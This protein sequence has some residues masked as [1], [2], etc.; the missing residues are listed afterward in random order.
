[1][2][3]T[4]DSISRYDVHYKVDDALQG[5][6]RED[7][8]RATKKTKKKA[9]P[10]KPR[11]KKQA[12]AR[13]KEEGPTDSPPAKKKRGRPPGKK[14]KAPKKE[15]AAAAPPAADPPRDDVPLDDG[16][17]PWRT[18]GHAYLGR[19]VRWTPPP[20]DAGAAA[21]PPRPCL[22]TV[23][24]WIAATDVDR[25]GDPG[26]VCSRTGRPARLF[27][28][29]FDELGQDLEEWELKECLL[30]DDEEGA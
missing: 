23:V 28:A 19:R 14:N 15:K 10:R 18:A 3:P 21:A 22:G 16:D 13:A 29:A 20:E 12:A 26:F 17:P 27:H 11:G 2:S 25:A 4:G 6:V 24:A 7:K 30:D 5:N 1:M 8:I 9:A